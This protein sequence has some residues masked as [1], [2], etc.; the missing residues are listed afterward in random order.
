MV[1][2]CR[3]ATICSGL[4]ITPHNYPPTQ[5]EAV[6]SMTALSS[7]FLYFFCCFIRLS[8]YISHSLGA[9]LI[10]SL[11]WQQKHENTEE[12]KGLVKIIITIKINIF[13]PLEKITSYASSI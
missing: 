5:I 3:S 11:R 12:R 13:Y 8:G 2:R 6:F 1:R 9:Y 7:I 10:A 4:S